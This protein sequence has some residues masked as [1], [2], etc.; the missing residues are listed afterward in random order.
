[1]N[2]KDL[3][4]KSRSN[5]IDFLDNLYIPEPTRSLLF[6]TNEDVSKISG[7]YTINLSIKFT[8][9]EI[10]CGIN[11]ASDL[12]S[13]PSV[14]WTR[15]PIMKN[16]YLEQEKMYY[17]SYSNLYPENRWQYLNWLNDVTKP[18][19]I[20]YVFLYYY[21]L[22][23]HLLFG[24]FELAF[25]E[26]IR[27]YYYHDKGTFRGYAKMALIISSLHRNRF[28]LIEKNF[29]LF[30]GTSNEEIL[31][32]KLLNKKMTPRDLIDLSTYVGFKNKR[33]IK[34]YPK[35][36]ESELGKVLIDY[37]SKNGEVLDMISVNKL[38][39]KPAIS[40][41]NF[42]LKEKVRSIMVPDTMSDNKFKL[43]CRTLL[44]NTHLN[45][46]NMKLNQSDG[47]HLF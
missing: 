17:P 41:A 29:D 5:E 40:F 2:K 27:L 37:Q 36:F 44:E 1:M 39:K 11:R 3:S 19:N 14:I 16:D 4:V 23:R 33:Y 8:E 31:I 38:E 46:K 22:E 7:P 30:S 24:N 42:S 18:T 26:I 21:G 35:E 34:L 6:V 45:I 28:D 15:L 20:S 12:Y 25:N 10:S 32:R 43:T 13:E 47:I 9:N